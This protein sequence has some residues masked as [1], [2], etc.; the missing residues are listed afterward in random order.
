MN[1]PDDP[2]DDL[3]RAHPS[4]PPLSPLFQ[5]DVERRLAQTSARRAPPLRLSWWE[6]F[7]RLFAQPAFAAVFVFACVLLGLLIGEMQASAQ[8]QVTHERVV[9]SYLQLL[10]PRIAAPVNSVSDDVNGGAE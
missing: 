1:V 2:L 4:P 9:Q 6:S 7:E 5:A 8:R 3:L 10:D